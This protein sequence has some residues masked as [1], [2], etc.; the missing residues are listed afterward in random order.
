L[1]TVA[2]AA[3]VFHRFPVS[4]QTPANPCFS[5]KPM[6]MS[7]NTLTTAEAYVE[8]GDCQCIQWQ[9]LDFCLRMQKAR[10]YAM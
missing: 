7:W 3:S 6:Q 2:G 4:F 5:E 8:A 10:P 9:V 1:F